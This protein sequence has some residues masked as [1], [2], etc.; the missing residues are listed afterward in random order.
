MALWLNAVS[1]KVGTEV[2]SARARS[3][4][5]GM[6]MISVWR[7]VLLLSWFRKLIEVRRWSNGRSSLRSLNGISRLLSSDGLAY[8]DNPW[9]SRVSNAIAL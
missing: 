5:E 8:T 2:E 9:R 4:S 3:L 7:S 6:V 1:S